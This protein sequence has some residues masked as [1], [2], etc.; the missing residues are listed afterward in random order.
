M[1]L[2][3]EEDNSNKLDYFNESVVVGQQINICKCTEE[4]TVMEYSN[5]DSQLVCPKCQSITKINIQINTEYNNNKRDLKTLRTFT[6]Y[7]NPILGIED[8][9]VNKID[10][11]DFNELVE[12]I[13]LNG[14]DTPIAKKRLTCITLRSFIKYLKLPNILNQHITKILIHF[15]VPAPYQPT[16]E[17]TETVFKWYID[18]VN[19]YTT[20]KSKIPDLIIGFKERDNNIARQYYIFKIID[21]I[22]RDDVNMRSLLPYIYLQQTKTI[23]D[24]DL[25]WKYICEDIGLD[26]YPTERF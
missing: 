12:Y 25:I 4:G 11:K 7:W 15:N 18:A 24:N 13:N 14:Y 9:S 6:N 5:I 10:E 19:S 20:I 17:E 8:W 22:W 23:S 2:F 1:A 26:Y 21:S 3:F 16:H